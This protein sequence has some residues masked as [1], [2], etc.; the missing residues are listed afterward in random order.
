MREPDVIEAAAFGMKPKA[1]LRHSLLTSSEAWTATVGGV[2]HAMFGLQ[3]ASALSG[4]AHPWMLGSDEIYRHPKAMMRGGRAFLA[5]WSDS[6][7]D[8]SVLVAVQN[9]RAIRFL[10]GC[11]FSNA[12]GG[13]LVF[14]GVEFMRLGTVT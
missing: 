14:A 4:K 11:G 7:P 2:P 1:A 12:E 10:R 8:M 6:T 9:V 13:D 5:R 3:I